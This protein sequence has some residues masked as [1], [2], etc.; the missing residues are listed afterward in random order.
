MAGT[1]V[2]VGAARGVVVYA[3]LVILEACLVGLDGDRDWLVHSWRCDADR[4]QRRSAR[5][6]SE[7]HRVQSEQGRVEYAL[8][9]LREGELSRCMSMLHS[10][11]LHDV[12]DPA[13]L[14]AMRDVQY[15]RLRPFPATPP[16][17]PAVDVTISLR[18]RYRNA[19]RRCG[20][21]L[22]G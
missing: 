5:R 2:E 3:A 16:P 17:V 12:S 19:R 11:G 15:P 10:L 7:P 18:E 9:M 22:S 6:A 4:A 21:G 14:Q 20:A 13:V 8:E 1:V